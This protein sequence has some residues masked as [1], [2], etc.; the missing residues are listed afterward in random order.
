M[1]VEMGRFW[2]ALRPGKKDHPRP[3]KQPG[4]RLEVGKARRQTENREFCRFMVYDVGRSDFM[5]GSTN[6]V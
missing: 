1:A 5:V 3:R 4:L 2:R 6:E